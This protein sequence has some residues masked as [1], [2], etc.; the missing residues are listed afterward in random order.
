MD[1]LYNI[2]ILQKSF[3]LKKKEYIQMVN[4]HLKNY[5]ISLVIKEMLSTFQEERRGAD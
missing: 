4:Y 3:F 5:S 2:I 1:E